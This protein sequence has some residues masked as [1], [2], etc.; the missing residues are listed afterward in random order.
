MRRA[1]KI[2]ASECIDANEYETVEDINIKKVSNLSLIKS[3]L[4]LPIYLRKRQKKETM[5]KKSIGR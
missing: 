5:K 1:N 3:F 2:Y 4:G